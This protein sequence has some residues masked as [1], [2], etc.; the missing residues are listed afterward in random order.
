MLGNALV[1]SRRFGSGCSASKQILA[2]LGTHHPQHKEEGDSLSLPLFPAYS[3]YWGQIFFL[4]STLTIMTSGGGRENLLCHLSNMWS[5]F[6]NLLRQLISGLCFLCSMWV[7]M[8][9]VYHFISLIKWR[10]VLGTDINAWNRVENDNIFHC[11]WH[12]DTHFLAAQDARGI[13]HSKI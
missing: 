2:S 12:F 5:I 7:K 13:R 6:H 10:E 9:T 4:H 1:L 11:P 8:E 3:V